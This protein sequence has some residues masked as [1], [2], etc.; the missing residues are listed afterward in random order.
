[1]SAR[2]ALA[3]RVGVLLAAVFVLALVPGDVGGCSGSAAPLDESAFRAAFEAVRCERCG[4]CELADCA[5]ACAGAAPI[6]QLAPGCEP[7]E[8]DGLT[9][10]RAIEHGDCAAI[11]RLASPSPELPPPCRFC[12]AGSP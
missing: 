8:Q 7:T 9:C 11:A 1:M 12:P 4:G 5:H 3:A 10:L 2:G 6:T